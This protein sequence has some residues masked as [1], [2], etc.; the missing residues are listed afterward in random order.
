MNEIKI[1]PGA[2]A[3]IGVAQ[4]ARAFNI[5]A[6]EWGTPGSVIARLV[7]SRPEVRLVAER[8][9]N[10]RY[11]VFV[12]LDDDPEDVLDAVF[13]AERRAMEQLPRIPFDL[14]VRKPHPDWSDR[15]LRAGSVAHYARP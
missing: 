1:T 8:Y 12:I 10:G 2:A 7:A 9:E 3:S 5:P 4:A 15:D 14:R 6:I 13:E 11:G